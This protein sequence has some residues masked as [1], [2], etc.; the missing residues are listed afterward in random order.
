MTAPTNTK[1]ARAGRTL[2]R[3]AVTT[4]AGIA[5]TLIPVAGTAGAETYTDPNDRCL[6]ESAAPQ[7]PVSDYARISDV[8]KQSVDCSFAEGYSTGFPDGTFRPADM[9]TRGQM[10]TFIVGA[11]RAAGYTLPAAQ[12]QPFT[13]IAGNTHEA[14][15][16][17][18]ATIGVTKGKTPT[19]YAPND[20]VRRDQM[21]SFMVQ[22]AE[23]A[24]EDTEFLVGDEPVPAFPD[25]L[26]NNVHY[27]NVNSGAR[28]LGLVDG[29]SSGLFDPG[30]F[31]NR[32]QMATFLVRLVDLTLLVQ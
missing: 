19:T 14:N 31:T 28:V 5:L 17:I 27:D 11:L 16:R 6:P 26:P 4:T 12:A 32:E 25:V 30:M 7:A 3:L 21:A 13:D 10:A 18:L 15:I 2:R 20:L 1:G 22:A 23:Y 9:T 8:H 24:Y 29:K